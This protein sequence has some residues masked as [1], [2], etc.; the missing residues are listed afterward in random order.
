MLISKVPFAASPP[1]L[2]A[3]R[4][5]CPS[6][7][8]RLPSLLLTVPPLTLAA[9]SSAAATP[10]FSLSNILFS[11]YWAFTS[12]SHLALNTGTIDFTITNSALDDNITCSGVNSN[13]W[14]VFYPSTVYPCVIPEEDEGKKKEVGGQYDPYCW[15][16]GASFTLDTTTFE[17]RNLSVEMSWTCAKF[18]TPSL[19]FPSF[20]LLSLSQRIPPGYPD[21]SI[22]RR[23]SIVMKG[24]ANTKQ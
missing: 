6:I 8:M 22:L 11:T 18:V 24:H 20:P 21:L 13:S 14:A 5:Y 9:D 15:A 2:Q 17:T 1:L 19:R 23:S 16:T 7:T 12:P 10:S 3:H 4:H